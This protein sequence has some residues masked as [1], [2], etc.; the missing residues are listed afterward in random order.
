MK[1]ELRVRKMAFIS[2][3]LKKDKELLEIMKKREDAMEQN[4]LQKADAFGYLYKEHKKEI[5]LLIEKRD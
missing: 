2:D 5:R 1:E 3:Q 4:M